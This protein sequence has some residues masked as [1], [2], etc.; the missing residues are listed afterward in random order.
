MPDS[1]ISSDHLM[2]GKCSLSLKIRLNPKL[3]SNANKEHCR[4]AGPVSQLTQSDSFNG[5][6]QRNMSW[7][8]AA[9]ILKFKGSRLS[10]TIQ[11][12]QH[13]VCLGK[14]Q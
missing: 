1:I 8:L 14:P 9:Q 2:P 7:K 5:I 3:K 13:V 11:S 6:Q 4:G 12:P 10:W